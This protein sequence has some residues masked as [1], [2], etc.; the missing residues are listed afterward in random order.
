MLLH[1]QEPLPLELEALLTDEERRVLAEPGVPDDVK[2]E[3]MTR[4][5]QRRQA[6]LED[7]AAEGSPP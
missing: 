6:D 7:E 2:A 5:E 4:L 3:I 1:P